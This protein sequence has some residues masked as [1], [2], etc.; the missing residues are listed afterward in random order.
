MGRRSK[1]ETKK[2]LADLDTRTLDKRAER[3]A[4]LDPL[5]Y[6]GE[7][8]L[9]EQMHDFINETIKGYESGCFRSCIFC[10]AG[11]VEYALRHEIIRLSDNPKETL[12][13]KDKSFHDIIKMAKDYEQLQAFTEDA[14]YLRKLR[15][16]IS[17]HPLYVASTMRKKPE[18]IEMEKE[19]TIRDIQ[20][21][22]KF[23]DPE[24]RELKEMERLIKTPEA[25]DDAIEWRMYPLKLL[26]KLALK[27]WVKM[28]KIIEG[29]YPLNEKKDTFDS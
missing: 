2:T 12:K 28:R 10:C 4:E 24:E 6:S 27:A 23:F 22:I 26:H 7:K 11:A 19:T 21:F 3:L 5:V 16:K 13:N 29:V 20:N 1:Q 8:P 9:S 15:N 17:A 25:L 18:E 14:H